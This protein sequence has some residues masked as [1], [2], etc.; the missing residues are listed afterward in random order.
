MCVLTNSSGDAAKDDFYDEL[1]R[2][3]D[4]R[5]SLDIVL[6]AGDFNAQLSEISTSELGLGGH[7]TLGTKRT[8]NGGS[9][10]HLC[11]THGLFRAN[12]NFTPKRYTRLR[13][14]HRTLSING[15]NLI[16]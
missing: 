5:Q 10:L 13:G 16:T 6:I 12:T 15:S 1:N 14:D 9:L 2:L 11:L 3:L 4:M 8:E 7:F